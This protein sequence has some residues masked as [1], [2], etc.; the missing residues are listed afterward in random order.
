MQPANAQQTTDQPTDQSALVLMQAH[1][2][3]LPKQVNHLQEQ[4]PAESNEAN[5]ENRRI[6]AGLAQRVSEL[7][8]VRE[9]FPAPP[10]GPV[11][12][13]EYGSD[14]VVV[15]RRSPR[16]QSSAALGGAGSSRC[17]ER[18]HDDLSP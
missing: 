18:V 13:C 7:E 8:P 4:P 9:A 2:D 10:G 12:H 11:S 15:R 17:K 3:S 1:L 16:S 5:R 6:I 14:G